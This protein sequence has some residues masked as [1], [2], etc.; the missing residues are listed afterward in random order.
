MLKRITSAAFWVALLSL[1]AANGLLIRQN[2]QMR[3]ALDGV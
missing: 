3:H 1:A 2:M